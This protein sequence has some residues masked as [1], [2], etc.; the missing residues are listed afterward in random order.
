MEDL[1]RDNLGYVKSIARRYHY[2]YP[3]SDLAE[4]VA[5]GNLGLV[6]AFSKFDPKIMPFFQGYA[7]YWIMNEIMQAL[8]KWRPQIF[9][10]IPD[11]SDIISPES[12]LIWL[13]SLQKLNS[14][15]D[16]VRPGLDQLDLAILENRLLAEDPISL[17]SLASEYAVTKQGVNYR[18]K[19]L[20]SKFQKEFQVQKKWVG[21]GLYSPIGRSK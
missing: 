4:L 6:I 11:T 17:V 2:K 3:G 18:E 20:I 7:F 10:Y 14:T 19:Q 15:L 16:K 5:A 21:T 13:Q 9:Q 1:I 8:K 12:E